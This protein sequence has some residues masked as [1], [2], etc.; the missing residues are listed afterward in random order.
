ML[1]EQNRGVKKENQFAY[2]L[3]KKKLEDAKKYENE[4]YILNVSLS[5]LKNSKFFSFF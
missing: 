4:Q 3:Q 1:A 2:E 5:L